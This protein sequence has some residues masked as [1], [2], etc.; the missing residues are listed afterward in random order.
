MLLAVVFLAAFAVPSL[1]TPQFT[2]AA[3][4]AS[5]AGLLLLL[6]AAAGRAGSGAWGAGAALLVLGSLVRFDACGLCLIVLAPAVLL[7]LVRPS[8]MPRRWLFCLVLGGALGTAG[9]FKA[10]NASWYA[11]IP[12][13]EDYYEF[14]RLQN[15][16]YL[17]FARDRGPAPDTCNRP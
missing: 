2:M 16:L 7:V 8:L 12:E 13:W 6:T 5:M 15:R 4:A 11:A 17:R 9:G 14:N 3:F 1:R 10:F